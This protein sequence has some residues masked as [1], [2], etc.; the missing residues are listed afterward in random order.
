MKPLLLLSLALMLL[1]AVKAIASDAQPQ[2]TLC[3]PT[4]D[5]CIYAPLS[6]IKKAAQEAFER[7]RAQGLAQGLAEYRRRVRSDA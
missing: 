5:P 7:G 4:S 2:K 6:E 3:P 1:V